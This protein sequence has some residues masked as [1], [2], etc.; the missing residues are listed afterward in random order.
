MDYTN[1]EVRKGLRSGWHGVRN[2]LTD[3]VRQ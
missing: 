3:C 1:H 2:D